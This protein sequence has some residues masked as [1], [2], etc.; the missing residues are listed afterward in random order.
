MV[1]DKVPYLNGDNYKN[2]RETVLFYLGYTDLDCAL[3]KEE[4]PTPTDTS[5]QA[6]IA[7][8]EQW[9]RSNHLSMMFIKSHIM[10]SIHGSI[11]KCENVKDLMDTIH[12]QF[13]TSDKASH[14][15]LMIRLTSMKL[16]DIKGV[17][18]HIM[19]MRD[20]AAQLRSLHMVINDDFLVHYA[21]NSLSSHYT[22]F[23]ISCDTQKAKWTIN[24]LLTMCVQEEERFL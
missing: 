14:S 3:C 4:P 15:T 5:T 18:E 19:K 8:Y 1:E 22:P 10:S 20:I 11:P 21:L 23:K 17:C 16:T 2:W 12:A 13:E 9:E 6:E 24:E 7:L